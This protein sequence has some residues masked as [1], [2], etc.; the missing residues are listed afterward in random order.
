MMP[1]AGM[2]VT[3]EVG[4]TVTGGHTT[5]PGEEHEPGVYEIHYTFAEHGEFEV[6]VDFEDDHA[7]HHHVAFH[8]PVS[9]GH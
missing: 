7:A 4:H 8:V 5:H 6:A 1:V 9:P 2:Q 3:I